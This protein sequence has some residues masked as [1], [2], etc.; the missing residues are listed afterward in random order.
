MKAKFYLFG[1]CAL[2]LAA[3]SIDETVQV[4][5]TDAVKF[6]V[7]AATR[8]AA[9]T[10]NN[11]E[12][13][14]V[15][16][17][18]GE[19]LFMD[20]VVAT[21]SGSSF[22][23]SPLYFWPTGT[24]DFYALTP[25]TTTT[26]VEDGVEYAYIG[27]EFTYTDD[28]DPTWAY[29]GYVGKAQIAQGNISLDV[30]IPG[31]AENQLDLCY[32]VTKEQSSGTVSM[33][34]RHALS[35]I[36]FKAMNT[37]SEMTVDIEGISVCS[38]Y[39]HGTYA[40]PTVNTTTN[41]PTDDLGTSGIADSQGSWA[42]TEDHKARFVAGIT[43]T[44][45]DGVTDEAVTLTSDDGSLML[46]PQEVEAW[47]PD[48]DATDT[49]LGAYIRIN[50]AVTEDGATIWPTE[51]EADA[52]GYGEIAVPVDIAWEEGWRYTYTIIFGDGLGYYPPDDENGEPGDPVLVPIT[53]TVSVDE[54]QVAEDT[55]LSTY[56]DTDDI[57]P[58]LI[59]ESFQAYVATNFDTDGNG[60]VSQAE[61]ATVTSIKCGYYP[62]DEDSN[63]PEVSDFTGIE[64][65]T[66]LTSF[67]SNTAEVLDLSKNTELTTLY[68]GHRN[69]TSDPENA[70]P[71]TT[72]DL[73]NNTKI[74]TLQ[75]YAFRACDK[76][77]S[78]VLP[79]SATTIGNYCFS[80]C[81]ALTTVDFGSVT[82]INQYAFEYC[83]VLAN[84]ALP[85]TLTTIGTDAFQYCL[86]LSFVDD[87][88]PDT[89]TSIDTGVFGY[90]GLVSVI[91]PAGVTEVPRTTFTNC[92]SL[93]NVTFPAEVTSIGQ[94]SLIYC[95][96]LAT[97][98]I[99]A[100]TP[101]TLN[102]SALNGAGN[103]VLY[104]P[105]ESVDAYE[106]WSSHVTAIYAIED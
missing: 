75:A 44:T 91:W 88:I 22:V 77:T 14:S 24:V 62:N 70:S 104:V 12:S 65:F 55:D 72:L 81:T 35:Q 93:A 13:F 17:W 30:Y 41:L 21:K 60:R 45:L 90:S 61:A 87:Q 20:D 18:N 69:V 106:G 8:A 52:N 10:T 95:G 64:Y 105:A 25:S 98:T 101:P 31:A 92:T 58:Y 54:F 49:E 100:T 63:Y 99:Y 71:I 76:L 11:L 83:S 74:T 57:L 103:F 32:A 40:L 96:A 80:N 6:K 46:L 38:V 1:L 59:D 39:S 68:L 43:A 67:E 5:D 97:M 51:S 28:E 27:G 66:A 33:N 73:S 84:V 53:F 56:V 23:T 48:A 29:T 16:A 34:F 42:T 7:T 3:C 85:S 36:V 2:A 19:T 9:T 26:G 89:V 37:N 79:S 47:D 78:I 94:N 15:W 82:T 86:A 50:C 4:N 102:S